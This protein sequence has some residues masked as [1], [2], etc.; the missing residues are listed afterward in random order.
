MSCGTRAPGTRRSPSRSQTNSA[1]AG[2]S[3]DGAGT[4]GHGD[5]SCAATGGSGLA[6]LA[7]RAASLG[8]TLTAGAGEAGGFRLRVNVPLVPAPAHAGEPAPPVGTRHPE[9]VP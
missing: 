5:A 9:R 8:G 4:G 7:E 3:D 2:L 1:G 6:G